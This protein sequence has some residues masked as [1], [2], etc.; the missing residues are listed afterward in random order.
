M[1]RLFTERGKS[2]I[3]ITHKLDE[4]IFITNRITVLRKGKVIDTVQTDQTSEQEV[5]R[6]MVGREVLF[7][8]DR[9]TLKTGADLLSIK[10][11]SV[12]GDRGLMAVKNLNLSI[13]AGEILGVAGVDGNGQRELCEAICGLRTVESGEIIVKG[14]LLFRLDSRTA[15][16][17]GIGYIPEDRQ[18]TGLLLEFSLWRNAILRNYANCQFCQGLFLRFKAIFSFTIGLIKSYDIRVQNEQVTVRT[19]S[20]GNQQKLVLARELSSNPDVLIANQPTRGLD[21]ASIEYVHSQLINQR[22]MN[23]AVLL[24]SRELNE[25]FSLSDRIAVMYGGEIVGLVDTKDA[26]VEKIGALMIGL[27]P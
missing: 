9:K 26:D 23:K 20:G 22:N 15:L 18:R 21:I 7:S 27:K 8:F 11:L 2:V 16:N 1:F 13:R 19:L 25:V 6:M 12:R 3:F 4:A 10:N 5:T 14:K 17:Q 24:V